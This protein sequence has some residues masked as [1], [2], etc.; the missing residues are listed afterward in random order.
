MQDLHLIAIG[1]GQLALATEACTTRAR[2][3]SLEADVVTGGGYENAGSVHAEAQ[4]RSPARPSRRCAKVKRDVGCC[5]RRRR[6][7]RRWGD[8]GR[9][10]RGTR[11]RSGRGRQ[12]FK[13]ESQIPVADIPISHI[14]GVC[15][16]EHGRALASARGATRERGLH[17]NRHRQAGARHLEEGADVAVAVIGRVPSSGN[18]RHRSIGPRTSQVEGLIFVD[19]SLRSKYGLSTSTYHGRRLHGSAVVSWKSTF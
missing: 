19:T 2:S 12:R 11:Q 18:N 10:C 15:R 9:V 7:G 14:A 17:L 3:R 1:L 16:V 5:G 6:G 4:T 13:V 8:S